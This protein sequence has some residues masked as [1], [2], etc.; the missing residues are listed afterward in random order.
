MFWMVLKEKTIKVLCDDR[1]P[2]SMDA[3]AMTVG[4]IEFERK[5]LKTGDYIFGNVCIER[6]AIDDFCASIMDDRL[7]NQI[8]KMKKQYDHIY[9]LVSGKIKD[10]VSD[11]HEN[12]ILGKMASIL[13]KHNISIIT[14][15]DEFQ[16]VYLMKRIFERHE[17]E[18]NNFLGFVVVDSEALKGGQKQWETEKQ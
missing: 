16:L 1:E 14:L 4:G 6:K 8:A 2:K 7:T 15:D 9:I 12:C 5:R 18:L 11:I 3:I 10:R 17:E 13:V